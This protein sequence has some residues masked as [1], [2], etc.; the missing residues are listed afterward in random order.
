MFPSHPKNAIEDKTGQNTDLNTE[1][2]RDDPSEYKSDQGQ[3]GVTLMGSSSIHCRP[4]VTV[5][6]LFP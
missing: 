1:H 3:H 5:N 4:R 2:P 6:K